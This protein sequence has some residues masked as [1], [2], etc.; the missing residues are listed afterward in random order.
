MASTEPAP[1]EVAFPPRV[2]V[3]AIGR[4]EGER[5]SACIQSVA[6]NSELVVYVD[7]GSTDESVILA[8]RAGA[9]AVTLDTRTPFTAARARNEGFRRLKQLAPKLRYVQFVDGDCEVER[10]WIKRA[11]DFLDKNPDVAVVCGRRRERFP[12]RSI[13]NRLCDAEWNTPIGR[14]I[15]CGGD[16]MVRTDAFEKARG[17]R[18]DLI[19]G[20]EPE[21]CLRLRQAGWKIWRLDAEMTLHDAGMTHISQWWRRMARSGYAFAQGSHLHGSTPERFWV[22]ESRRAWLWGAWMPLACAVSI[23]AFGRWG[24][25]ALLIYPLQLVRRMTNVSGRLRERLLLIVFE[26]LGRFPETY[27]QARFMMDR[28]LGRAG[29]LIE[30]K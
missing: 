6:R 8:K 15:G 11:A 12:E 27:G 29:Q 16:A 18:P 19:A 9:D 2:G 24:L 30:Y 25:L 17:Y 20:E 1:S 28:M 10:S 13:Y 22:R 21:L 23:L 26:M 4:N 14:A 5:L 7:S 3:V